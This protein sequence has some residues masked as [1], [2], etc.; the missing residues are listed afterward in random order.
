MHYRELKAFYK[1]RILDYLEQGDDLVVVQ[2][3]YCLE[4]LAERPND[5][6]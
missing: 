6:G 4:S 2:K 1:S 3:G 5:L